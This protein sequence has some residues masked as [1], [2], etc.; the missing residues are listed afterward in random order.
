MSNSDKRIDDIRKKHFSD[1]R[2][3]LAGENE[4]A[5]ELFDIST[6]EIYCNSGIEKNNQQNFTG[7]VGDFTIAIKMNKN[8]IEAYRNRS[9]SMYNLKKYRGA[10]SDCTKVIQLNLKA[11]AYYRRGS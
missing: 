3:T 1:L 10:T 8:N 11:I 6:S 5:Q 2:K 7:A 4:F 9:W